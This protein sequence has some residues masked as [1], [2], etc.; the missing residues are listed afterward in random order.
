[1]FSCYYHILSAAASHLRLLLVYCRLTVWEA[2]LY[3]SVVGSIHSAILA[4]FEV[5]KCYIWAGGW[6][7]YSPK[8]KCFLPWSLCLI[9][10]FFLDAC[11]E[12]IIAPAGIFPFSCWGL[13]VLACCSVLGSLWPNPS[14]P[15]PPPKP[16]TSLGANS[17]SSVPHSGLLCPRELFNWVEGSVV[18]QMRQPHRLSS[19]L[20]GLCANLQ[21]ILV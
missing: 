14:D 13:A 21:N 9:F 1:M 19:Y 4:L 8:Y 15:S 10:L 12:G 5:W 3:K 18:G 6:C 7:R 17:S 16:F 20:L 2:L 11:P